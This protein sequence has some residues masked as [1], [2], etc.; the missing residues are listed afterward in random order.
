MQSLA[1]QLCRSMYGNAFD[2]LYK[3]LGEEVVNAIPNADTST[4]YGEAGDDLEGDYPCPWTDP[5]KL[6]ADVVKGVLPSGRPFLV[7]RYKTKDSTQSNLEFFFQRYSHKRPMAAHTILS[8]PVAID[9]TRVTKISQTFDLLEEE[10]ASNWTATT[11][12][13]KN[14]IFRGSQITDQN[15]QTIKAIIEGKPLA[16]TGNRYLPIH[17]RNVFAAKPSTA[18]PAN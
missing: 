13:T 7:I 16:E 11:A 12:Y 2:Y 9:K 14:P 6:N 8:V 10:S 4:I 1:T 5:S 15:F 18:A 17:E 3:Q